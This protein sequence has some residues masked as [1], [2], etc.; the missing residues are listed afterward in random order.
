MQYSS[1]DCCDELNAG[2]LPIGTFAA[3]TL[4]PEGPAVII[5]QEKT[6]QSPGELERLRLYWSCIVFNVLMKLDTHQGKIKLCGF[7][8]P[9]SQK[10]DLMKIPMHLLADQEWKE[11][12]HVILSRD[13][14]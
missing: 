7:A 5:K 14:P 4:T 9:I 12:S 11:L 10:N 2:E 3:V 6:T 13:Q 8:I 1:I